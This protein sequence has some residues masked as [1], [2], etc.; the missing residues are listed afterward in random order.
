METFVWDRHFT[1]D[2]DTVD[3]QHHALVDL[4]NRLGEHLVAGPADDT[5]LEA[6]FGQLAEYAIYHFAEEENLMAAS[7]VD[8]RHVDEHKDLHRRFVNQVQSMWHARRTIA[9]ATTVLHE[10]LAAWLSF[11]ILGEDQA[12]A[13]QIKRIAEG[14][15]PGVAYAREADP[16]D[17]ATT[18]LLGA[19]RNL[20]HVLSAQNDDLVIANRN[21]EQRVAERTEALARAN[22]ALTDANRQLE[23]ASRTD[24][25]LGIANR[26]Y[27]DEKLREEWQRG[28]RE[29]HP[30]GLI[31]LDVDHFKRYNDSYGHIAGDACLRA[32]AGAA[33]GALKRPGD[34]IA[35]YGGEE[36]VI[37]LPHTDVAGA[38][39][40]A[41]QVLEHIHALALPHCDSPVAPHV[42]VSMGV[43]SRF[44]DTA[45]SAESLIA[46]ADAALYAAKEAGRNRIC[47]ATPHDPQAGAAM[48]DQPTE[49]LR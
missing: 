23:K 16:V 17:N 11:H 10:F 1:T 21:L 20:Y 30:L 27:F 38:L 34:L 24:G 35:R 19:L 6:I 28:R 7:G 33:G 46:A 12:M 3:D 22:A 48:P 31:M 18:A 15:S 41:R 42:T 25:L 5:D 4:I 32:V 47:G 43:A 14:E 13:R 26:K 29:R 45:R 40:V 2:L 49:G 36:L 9:T 37:M 44:A 8:P 39:A